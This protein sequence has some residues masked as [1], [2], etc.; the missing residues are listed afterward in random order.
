MEQTLPRAVFKKHFGQANHYLITSLVSLYSLNESTIS[1][2]PEDMH[3]SWNPKDKRSSIDRTRIFM[4]NSFLGWAVDSLDMYVSLLNRNPKY[5]QDAELTST[6]DNAG[7]SV[8]K[9]VITIGEYY[10]IHPAI[11]SLVDVLI[12]WRNNVFH[13]LADNS[14]RRKSQEAITYNQEYINTNFRGLIAS[15]LPE[16][17]K[18]GENL[19]FKETASLINAT[20]KY[21]EDVDAAVINALDLAKFCSEAV[22][23]EL[24]NRDKKPDF[25]SKYYGI[26]VERRKLFIA[27]FFM[28]KYH[29][30]DI[31][32]KIIDACCNLK[33]ERID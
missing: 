29:L 11:L 1:S 24:T 17:A 31:E 4:L 23:K 28:N 2:A 6:L 15:S 12:T 13:D 26:S 27:N 18:R 16:K 14:I 33:T 21:V 9:K 22:T 30:S 25:Y 32:A 10:N 19:T 8:L 20:H 7:R 3:T 5:I